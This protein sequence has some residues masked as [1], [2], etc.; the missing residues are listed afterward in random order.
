VLGEIWRPLV[1]ASFAIAGTVMLF[2]SRRDDTKL[3][4]AAGGATLVFVTFRLFFVD[5][6]GV[7]TIWRVLLFLGIGALFLFTS[8]QLQVGRE[9]AASGST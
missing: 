1:T 7:D 9:T 8:R 5:M 2:V 3:L 4:R 6:Q